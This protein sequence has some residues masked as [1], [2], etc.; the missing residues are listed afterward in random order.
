MLLASAKCCFEIL[1]GRDNCHVSS[2]LSPVIVG[3]MQPAAMSQLDDYV[4]S[5]NIY[6]DRALQVI[7]HVSQVKP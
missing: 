4:F 1:P 6:D 5:G 3:Q 2:L 7:E